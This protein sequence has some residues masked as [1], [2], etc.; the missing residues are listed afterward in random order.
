MTK[1]MVTG[2]YLACRDGSHGRD[3]HAPMV[4]I[5]MAINEVAVLI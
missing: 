5:S 4:L 3:F 1:V 2:E